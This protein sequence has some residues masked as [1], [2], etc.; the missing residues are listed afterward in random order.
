MR[1]PTNR[2]PSRYARAKVAGAR[3][4][5]RHPPPVRRG[6][7]TNTTNPRLKTATPEAVAWQQMKPIA[8]DK[9]ASQGVRSNTLVT[10][11]ITDERATCGGHSDKTATRSHATV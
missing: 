6:G 1:Q 9:P 2:G 11:Q 3:G 4:L 10:A 5:T 7:T 8:T